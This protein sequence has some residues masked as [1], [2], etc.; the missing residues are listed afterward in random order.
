ML[1]SLSPANERK[2]LGLRFVT[3]LVETMHQMSV[4]E[5]VPSFVYT[6][7]LPTSRLVTVCVIARGFVVKDLVLS[8]F[9]P[10]P[11]SFQPHSSAQG[12]RPIQLRCEHKSSLSSFAEVLSTLLLLEEASEIDEF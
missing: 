5:T 11:K 2:D 3:R 1:L 7:L 4:S 6:A 9:C 12:S 8:K 10:Q